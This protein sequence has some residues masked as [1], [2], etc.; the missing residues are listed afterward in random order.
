MKITAF[1]PLKINS[2]RLE[3][4]NF[5][6]L[7]G[8]PLFVHIFEKLLLT[9]QI[10]KVVCWASDDLYLDYL[11]SGIE[12]VKREKFLDGDDITAKQLFTAA[13]KQINSEFLLLSHATSPFISPDSI[14]KGI[15]AISQGYDSSFSVSEISTY[16]WYKNSPLNYDLN[17][18]VKTQDLESIYFETSGFFIFRRELML[19]HGRRIGDNSKMIP[20]SQIESIDIDNKEDYN[21]AKLISPTL[22]RVTLKINQEVFLLQKKYQHIIP[23]FD[24]VILDSIGLMSEAWSASGG[25]EYDS[26]D[27]YKKHI[28]LPFEEICLKLN[29]PENKIPKI[30][31]KYF[32]YTESNKEKTRLYP[33]VFKTFQ[34]LKRAEIK[35][36]IISSKQYSNILSL[37]Q[38]HDLSVDNII[39]PIAPGKPSY[40]GRH[41]PHGDPLLVACLDAKKPLNKSI[42]IGDMKS[43]Y[44][45]AVN[46]NIDFCFAGWGYGSQNELAHIDVPVLKSF[47]LLELIAK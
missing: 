3:C 5:L 19:N 6:N 23:D 33:D 44:Q 4:K 13:V 24:G 18:P 2:Q 41:K 37:L 9:P 26:F 21:L 40:I 1:V 32:K 27:E 25:R 34:K 46:A 7:E 8:K 42:F 22:S 16:C 45:A 20:V 38:L 28:G 15:E 35:I 11:P 14:S 47:S 30:K 36:T 17:N 31:E 39:A 43:D 12:F 10:E 29:I